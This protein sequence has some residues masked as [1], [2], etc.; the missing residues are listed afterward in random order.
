MGKGYEIKG[1][2]HTDYGEQIGE[3]Y[4]DL[5]NYVVEN[6]G[7][8]EWFNTEE[9]NLIITDGVAIIVQINNELGSLIPYGIWMKKKKEMQRAKFHEWVIA[10]IKDE[11]A[12][13]RLAEYDY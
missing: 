5:R 7:W 10:Y 8:G 9:R 4:G 6:F 12:S 13:R 11:D 3:T 1:Y 2:Y